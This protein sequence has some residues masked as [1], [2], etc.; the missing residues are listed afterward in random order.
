MRRFASFGERVEVHATPS[1]RYPL[2]GTRVK[3][4]APRVQENKNLKQL[5][6]V[7]GAQLRLGVRLVVSTSAGPERCA[8]RRAL[9]PLRY[10]LLQPP[11]HLF[12]E[13]A[14]CSSGPGTSSGPAV[15]ESKNAVPHLRKSSSVSRSALV[16]TAS[17]GSPVADPVMP[18][19]LQASSRKVIEGRTARRRTGKGRHVRAGLRTVGIAATS[20]ADHHDPLPHGFNLRGWQ[21]CFQANTAPCPRSAMI[22]SSPDRPL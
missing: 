9:P 3:W 12:P 20:E 15:V 1:D 13:T 2:R 18:A 7:G 21:E 14:A 19:W 22:S 17:Q 8:T 5:A 6:P 16:M 11:G 10:D 4:L